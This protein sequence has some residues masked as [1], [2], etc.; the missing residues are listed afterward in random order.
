MYQEIKSSFQIIKKKISTTKTVLT[1]PA[2]NIYIFDRNSKLLQRE[3]A[4]K[5][6]DVNVY[7]YI[8]DEIGCRL[9]DRIFDVN[10][11]FNK[12]LDLGCGRGH[13]SKCLVKEFV[14]ELLLADLSPSWLK[15]AQVANGIKIE[16]KVLDEETFLLEPN[17][18]DFVISCLS[19]HWVN[20]LPEC[21][22]CIIN[23]LKRDG[24]FMAA[25]FGID[26]LYELRLVSEYI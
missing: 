17:S 4:A 10:R 20:N 18:L 16:K 15:Q 14:S 23:S 21:F 25:I 19:L 7:D 22:N 5:A 8:K 6:F 1:V 24:L 3:R 9:S 11:K 2:N 12:V 26:T 13:V